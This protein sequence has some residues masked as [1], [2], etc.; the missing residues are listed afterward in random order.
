MTE[1]KQWLAESPMRVGAP[2]LRGLMQ[3]LDSPK[4]AAHAIYLKIQ[5]RAYITALNDVGVID[6]DQF[7]T[8][9]REVDDA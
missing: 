7:R 5:V 2:R 1:I 3:Q 4:S 6:G 9:E 8:F